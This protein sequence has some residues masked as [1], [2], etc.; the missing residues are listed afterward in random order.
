MELNTQLNLSSLEERAVNLLGQGIAAEAV[1][2]ALGVTPARISQMLSDERIANY[3]STLKYE[4]LQKH[5]KRDNAYDEIED[6][7]LEKLDK[8]IPLMFKP[9]TILKAIQTVNGAKRRGQTSSEQVI[10]PQNIV[11]IN[12]PVTIK[13]KFV[14]NIN[15]QVVQAGERELQTI[16][17]AK[18]LAKVE[19]NKL[20]TIETSNEY[21]NTNLPARV[22]QKE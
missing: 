4:N 15:N 6:R 1:A 22:N 13:Q 21:E 14:T 10:N 11:N 12:L 5:N 16:S 2:A 20:P 19:Q 8:S 7:L 3:V 18:L 9:E 17:S